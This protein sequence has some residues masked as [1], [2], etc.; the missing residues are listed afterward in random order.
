MNTVLADTPTKAFAIP[1]LAPGEKYIGAIINADGTGHHII[2]LAGDQA[3]LTWQAARDWATSIGGTLP[4]RVEQAMLFKHHR[5]DFAKDYYWSSEE[6]AGLESY[7]WCQGFGSGNQGSWG[8]GSEF[9]ARA[10]RRLPIQ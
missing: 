4:D 8:K 9:R 5:A 2:L 6:L 3:E 7:A 1:E 10:V